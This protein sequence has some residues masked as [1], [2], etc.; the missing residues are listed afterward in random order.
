MNGRPELTLA[1]LHVAPLSVSAV[2]AEA[3]V[4]LGALL[5]APDTWADGDAVPLLW[6]W[7]CFTPTARSTELG[8]DGHPATAPHPLL[9]GLVRRMWA[10][11]HVR[12]H[13]P[14]RIGTPATRRSRITDA[15]LKSGRS[16]RLLLVSIDHEI[17]QDGETVISERQDIV[18]REPGDPTPMPSGEHEQAAPEGGWCDVVTPDAVTLF[19]FSAVT[20]NSHRIH[21][22]AEYARACEGY[23]ALVVHGPLTAI[24]LAE[25]ARRRG[26]SGAEFSF[27]AQAP[28]FAGVP[29]AL[30]GE[31][32]DG[33]HALRAVRNDG[34]EAMTAILR[35]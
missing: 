14:L 7:A 3:F 18:Y 33:G 23:P 27:R 17:E 29:L 31:P 20:F 5:D 24:C 22:D 34:V 10:G 11:G 16:G 19:R 15:A 28:L 21:Y 2:D 26:I 6:H 12:R 13:R 30:V 8:S 35:G 9:D 4:R 32:S 25:S 1:D